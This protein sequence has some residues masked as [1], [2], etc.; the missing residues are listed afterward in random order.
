[1]GVAQGRDGTDLVERDEREGGG[2]IRVVCN[3]R[4][5]DCLKRRNKL[6]YDLLYSV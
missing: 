3:G 5:L 1:M 6:S 4:T 2:R